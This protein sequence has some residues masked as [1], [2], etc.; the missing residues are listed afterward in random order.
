MT[1]PS[2]GSAPNPNADP[3]AKDKFANLDSDFKDKVASLDAKGIDAVLA[4]IAKDTE[5]LLQAK[6]ADADLAAK[7]EQFKDAGQVYR[8]GAKENRLKTRFCMRVLNDQGKL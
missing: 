6:D 3:N 5:A 8:D 1:R 7:K 2:I 4:Q